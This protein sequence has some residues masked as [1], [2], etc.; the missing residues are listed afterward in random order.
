M[1]LEKKLNNVNTNIIKSFSSDI[2]K[3]AIETNPEIIKLLTE[4][5]YSDIPMAVVRELCINAIDANRAANHCPL[6]DITI[7]IPT[8]TEP[9]FS[10]EDHGI[11]MTKDEVKY[12]FTTFFKS[13][14]SEDNENAGMY[15]LGS[16]TPLAY[17][18]NF[19]ITSC[20]NNESNTFVETWEDNK[21]PEISLIP[22]S[23]KVCDKSGTKIVVPVKSDDFDKF[24]N[25]IINVCLFLPDIPKFSNWSESHGNNSLGFSIDY[26]EF[27]K[28]VKAYQN[29]RFVFDP[30]P[31]ANINSKVVL[32]MGNIGYPVDLSIC[33]ES[34]LQLIKTFYKLIDNVHSNKLIIKANIGDVDVNINR[35]SLRATEKTKDFLNS[36]IATTIAELCTYFND[37]ND[38][39]KFYSEHDWIDF[40]Q[41]FNL[42]LFG[43][44]R[45]PYNSDF[46]KFYSMFIQDT[47]EI[48]YIFSG[49]SVLTFVVNSND[50]GEFCTYIDCLGDNYIKYAY[51]PLY[52]IKKNDDVFNLK[53][54]KQGFISGK[55]VINRIKSY[56]NY[57]DYNFVFVDDITL[58][59][60]EDSDI[61]YTLLHDFISHN[62]SD[63]QWKEQKVFTLIEQPTGFEVAKLCQKEIE[64]ILNDNTK[65]LPVV[66]NKKG[67]YLLNLG[68]SKNVL[69]YVGKYIRDLSRDVYQN[70]KCCDVI[71]GS[72]ENIQKLVSLLNK[73]DI[74]NYVDCIK[75]RMSKIAETCK[76]LS[77]CETNNFLQYVMNF[78]MKDFVENFKWPENSPFYKAYRFAVEKNVFDDSSIIQKQRLLYG[79]DKVAYQVFNNLP[80]KDDEINKTICSFLNSA[81]TNF[82]G[83]MLHKYPLMSSNVINNYSFTYGFTTEPLRPDL[84][85]L[86]EYFALY[87]NAKLH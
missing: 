36:W 74:L 72:L 79:E 8:I 54:N 75:N 23:T 53:K 57:K 17:T 34:D 6:G 12:V 84:E 65:I 11:G 61:K 37:I 9:F 29:T 51:K 40:Q 49:C 46:K 5:L 64:S 26:D 55:Y 52:V 32:V 15:G 14:K 16:K 66:K 7:H 2:T 47:M 3:V 76:G 19:K 73:S 69:T 28:K 18:K 48:G 63:E 81:E 13:T 68:D 45:E 20:K 58:R 70:I 38:R 43:V 31:S 78:K 1:I 77:S 60:L 27:L 71:I 80:D 42:C 67:Y 44:V 50:N 21:I 86:V 4:H 24:F 25:S 59:R 35:E 39:L 85:N 83:K 82:T 56:D 62:V 22:G 10:V 87:D 33:L 30:Y 41:I